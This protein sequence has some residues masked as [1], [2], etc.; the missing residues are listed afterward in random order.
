[1]ETIAKTGGVVCTWPFAYVGHRSQRITLADW[2]QEI[3]QMKVRLGIAHCG[4]GTDGGGG[5]PRM[6]SGWASIAS[7]SAL[8]EAMK[9]AS[10]TTEDIGAVVGG[11]FLRVLRKCLV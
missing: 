5:L 8:M 4:I 3:V 9:T 11:N 1:M 7:L 10:L 2:V 6:V